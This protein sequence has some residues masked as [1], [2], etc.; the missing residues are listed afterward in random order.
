V[1]KKG[2]ST[3]NHQNQNCVAAALRLSG[4]LFTTAE[5]DWW[6]TEFRRV[7]KVDRLPRKAGLGYLL[8]AIAHARLKLDRRSLEATRQDDEPIQLTHKPVRRARAA[9]RAARAS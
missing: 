9:V 4:Y 7:Q 6:Q 8:S 2:E 1:A 5:W 3:R